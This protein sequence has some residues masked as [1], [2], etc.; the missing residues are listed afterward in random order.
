MRQAQADP[1]GFHLAL[2]E[3]GP[4]V[5]YR[6]GLW[7][8]IFL[9]HPEAV[10]HVLQTNYRNYSKETFAY[11]LVRRSVG[12]GLLTLDGEAW[13]ARRR[14]MQPA[15]HRRI[16]ESFACTGACPGWP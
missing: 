11:A 10:G 2:A 6:A 16:I 3:V 5:T 12:M 4:V 15:F 13:L 9:S 14:L 1:L 8:V 7:P